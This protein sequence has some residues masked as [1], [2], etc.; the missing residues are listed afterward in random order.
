MTEG[1]KAKILIF[2]NRKLLSDD[3]LE[4]L[5][6]HAYECIVL[7]DFEQALLVIEQA[8]FDIVR[9]DVDCFPERGLELLRR[10]KVSYPEAAFVMLEK[11]VHSHFTPNKVLLLADV[12]HGQKTLSEFLPF[13]KSVQMIGGK[14]TMYI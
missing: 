9:C 12:A 8:L 1:A 3:L 6:Q 11:E 10:C 7:R 14:T 13:I 2:D 5:D 4:F